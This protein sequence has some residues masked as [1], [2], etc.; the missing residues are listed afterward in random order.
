MWAIWVRTLK[1]QSDQDGD[2]NDFFQ[3]DQ[4]GRPAIN[5]VFNHGA[6]KN[7]FNV[8]QPSQMRALFGESFENTLKSFGYDDA[9]ADAITNILL[10]DILTYD[11]SSSAGFL[12]G[13]KLTDDVIDISLTLVTNG[14]VTTDK[15]GPH[16]DYLDEFP[17]VGHP[18]Q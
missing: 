6:A 14:K 11:Y 4:M 17:Y 3:N 5:T 9:H 18:H 15:V 13:R 1:A 2:P 7:T 10:P 12:N 16:T 8:T